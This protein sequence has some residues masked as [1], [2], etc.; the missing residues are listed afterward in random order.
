MFYGLLLYCWCCLFGFY[1]V[2]ECLVVDE[3]WV[4]QVV[5]YCDVWS[6]AGVVVLID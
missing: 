3:E 2:E 1:I 5:G 6:C 4:R